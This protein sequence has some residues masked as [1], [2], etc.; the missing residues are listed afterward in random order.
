GLKAA[1]S[2]ASESSRASRASSR[3]RSGR[4]HSHSHHPHRSNSKSSRKSSKKYQAAST[5]G[6]SVG[7]DSNSAR[8]SRDRDSGAFDPVI[9]AINGYGWGAGGLKHTS[10]AGALGGSGHAQ[11]R[12]S[13]GSTGG[14]GG[15]R[16]S[17]LWASGP[18]RRS[19]DRAFSMGSSSTAGGGRRTSAANSL[20]MIPGAGT[21]LHCP[22][23]EIEVAGCGFKGCSGSMVRPPSFSDDEFGPELFVAPPLPPPTLPPLVPA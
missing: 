21:R 23:C 20:V 3:G 7:G 1:T 11:K 4:S 2:G 8:S 9:M 14:G 12:K 16:G 17:G 19:R 18:R 10:S 5:S 6:G 15:P 13:S 22:H